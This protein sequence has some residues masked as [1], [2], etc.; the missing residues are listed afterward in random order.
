MNYKLKDYLITI[1]VSIAF[2]SREIY[3]NTLY[4]IVGEKYFEFFNLIVFF[5]VFL[6]FLKNIFH[7]KKL[8]KNIVILIFTAIF[9]FGFSFLSENNDGTPLLMFFYLIQAS[10]I[11]SILKFIN[12]EMLWKI[13]CIILNIAAYFKLFSLYNLG[14]FKLLGT[15]DLN[16]QLFSYISALS[17]ILLVQLVF[18]KNIFYKKKLIKLITISSIVFYSATLI[19]YGG[20]GAGLV[21]FIFIIYSISKYRKFINLKKITLF[22]FT[23]ISFTITYKYFASDDFGSFFLNGIDRLSSIVNQDGLGNREKPWISAIEL[24]KDKPILGYGIFEYIS[25]VHPHNIFLQIIL[26]FGIFSGSILS[27]ILLAKLYLTSRYQ[28]L[29]IYDMY[30]I[31]IIYTLTYLFFSSN[32]LISNFFWILILTLTTPSRGKK[33]S[34]ILIK[35]KASS[36]NIS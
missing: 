18:V 11:I 8:S 10:M 31:L 34:R 16:Y 24:I 29:F 22:T 36:Y 6:I 25:Y 20:R 27:V 5:L 33:N 9:I 7:H 30:N 17:I 2:L 35:D 14:L 23:V 19:Y 15:R 28:N 21:V 32:Y 26:Q 3:F 1:I 13:I 12:Q 4:Y